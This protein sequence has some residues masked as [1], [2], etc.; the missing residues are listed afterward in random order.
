MT[1]K[2]DYS[3]YKGI[4]RLFDEIVQE[5]IGFDNHYSDLY[6][7]VTTVT[8]RILIRREI[9]GSK[10]VSTFRSNLPEDNGA[11]WYDVSFAFSPYW[12]EKL[13]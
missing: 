12:I 4:E 8:R 7:P 6:I 11:D 13:S 2:T 1:D 10:G 3:T 9:I 5:G